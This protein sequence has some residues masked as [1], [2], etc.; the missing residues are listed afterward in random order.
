[1]SWEHASTHL[2]YHLELSLETQR[3]EKQ[4]KRIISLEEVHLILG[5]LPFVVRNGPDFK[6]MAA[7]FG[8]NSVRI[9][10]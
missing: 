4:G 3:W 1:M 8:R 6:V 7:D 10:T 2:I 5:F 9:D